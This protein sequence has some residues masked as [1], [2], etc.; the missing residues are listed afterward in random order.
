MDSLAVNN[1]IDNSA[2]NIHAPTNFG[3]NLAVAS[4]NNAA[5]NH[6]SIVATSSHHDMPSILVLI[7]PTVPYANPFLDIFK[8]EVLEVKISSDDKSE[9][10]LFLTCTHFYLMTYL[11]STTPIKSQGNIGLNE[12]K[13]TAEDAGREKLSLATFTGGR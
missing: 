11:T 9:F 3:I 5:V 7:M 6:I 4:N 10:I 13:Y 2:S 8:L 1:I 12:L